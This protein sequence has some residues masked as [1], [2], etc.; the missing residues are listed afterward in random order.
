MFNSFID[1][2][3]AVGVMM[4]SMCIRVYLFLKKKT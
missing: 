3:V 4:L 1:E 2:L